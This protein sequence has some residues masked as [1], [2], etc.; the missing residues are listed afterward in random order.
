MQTQQQ[1][2]ILRVAA[3]SDTRILSEDSSADD[4]NLEGVAPLKNKWPF[5]ETNMCRMHTEFFND[6]KESS[7]CN[8]A[9]HRV[10]KHW[11]RAA[12]FRFF[13]WIVVGLMAYRWGLV[14]AFSSWFTVWLVW[15]AFRFF[16]CVEVGL[17]EHGWWWWGLVVSFSSW[18]TVWLL[19]LRRVN[20]RLWIIDCELQHLSKEIEENIPSMKYKIAAGT[21]SYFTQGWSKLVQI[22]YDLYRSNQKHL[23]TAKFDMLRFAAADEYYSYGHR[24]GYHFVYTLQPHLLLSM[25]EWKAQ[26]FD[27]LRKMKAKS[28]FAEDVS[29][30]IL[31]IPYETIREVVAERTESL[32]VNLVESSDILQSICS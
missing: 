1:H 3:S 16:D 19:R 22:P 8:A 21:M 7:M 11:Q 6:A 28:D 26:K 5:D 4:E 31:D 27:L 17:M 32:V 2:A 9:D 29:E 15:S 10:E 20:A 25:A 13:V 12:A 23:L 18:F 30:I 24:N 14:I